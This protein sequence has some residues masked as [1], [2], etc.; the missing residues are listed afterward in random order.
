MATD[1]A[2][3]SW[4][5]AK[6]AFD[7]TGSPRKP[8]VLSGNRIRDRV[9]GRVVERVISAAQ[10]PHGPRLDEV[11][12]ETLYAEQSRLDGAEEDPRTEADRA[13]VVWLR[14][15]VARA[16]E[17]RYGE[18]VYA[19]VARYVDEISGH[20]NPL[21][22]RMA[23]RVLPPALSVLLHGLSLRSPRAFD[24]EDRILIEG[25]VD[26]LRS[27]SR[28]GTVVLAPTHVSNLDSLVLG[29][30]IYQLGLPPF[31][32]GA[33][34]NLFS[35]A[36]IGFFMRHLGA[37]TVDR[38]KTDPLYRTTLKEYTTVLLECGQ[39][40]LFFP[41]GTR[42]RSGAIESRLKL[43]MLGTAPT[44]FRHAT[45]A[46]VRHPRIFVVPCTLTYP[47]VLE[48]ST[49][50]GEYLR[51]EGGPHY[52]DTRDEFDRPRRWLDFLAGLRQL[53]LRVHLSIARP[54]DWLGNEV[55][56]QGTSH[57]RTGRPIDP[58][59]YLTVAGN[60]VQ[61]D[62]RDAAYTR[63]LSPSL[64]AAYRRENVALPTSLV[65]FVLFDRLRRERPEPSLFRFMR[66]LGPER[67]VFVG[68]LL[69]DMRRA[70]DALPRLE[71]QGSIR[72][73]RALRQADAGRLLDEA[74]ATFGTY[75]VVPVLERRDDRVFVRDPGLLFYYQ[76]RLAGY[77]L[78]E[79]G[80][81]W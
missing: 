59:R 57:D 75:H 1:G 26:A 38:K 10:K 11:V 62:A 50:V 58:A 55:D 27:L 53:D 78:S 65:A 61:D 29:S 17:E 41:G 20:F 13:F 39:H 9:L 45:D 19:I 2:H 56:D 54:L 31:A 40:A 23:T 69:I 12:Y 25:E 8:R 68:D 73:S 33:G 74:L 79:E 18:L 66:S 14:R 43:G 72:C 36:L 15:E 51:S 63:L 44:A 37:Y 80:R 28:I 52:V 32:Y 24:I 30:A 35:N 7:R 81:T 5:D 34:L 76:N 4:S 3:A 6:V 60:L 77:G 21:V 16:G 22:Y 71:R 46:G 64:V 49:L 48:A 67:S 70:L 47:L 42:S